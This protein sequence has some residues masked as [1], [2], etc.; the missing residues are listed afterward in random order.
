MSSDVTYLEERKQAALDALVIA[1]KNALPFLYEGV[2]HG[3]PRK[4]RVD[5]ESA[6]MRAEGF[7]R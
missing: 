2:T 6:I 1:A 3:D 7:A 4:T 5:L